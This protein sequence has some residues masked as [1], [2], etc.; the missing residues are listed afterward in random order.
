ML[1]RPLQTNNMYLA[2]ELHIACIHI[3]G[4]Y[5]VFH[6]FSCYRSGTSIPPPMSSQYGGYNSNRGK[7]AIYLLYTPPPPQSVFAGYT[8]IT[9]SGHPSKCPIVQLSL[10][11]WY[12]WNFTQLY[13]QRC[14]WR[15]IILVQTISREINSSAGIVWDLTHR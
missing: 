5:N 6:V 4:L 9:L 2:L 12:W 3:E 10:M 14:A 7:D 15:R 13:N 8:V 1:Q 11:N